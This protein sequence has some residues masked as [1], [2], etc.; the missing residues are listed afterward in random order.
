[1]RIV[2]GRWRGRTIDAPKGAGTR[3]TADRVRESLM[4]AL[5]SARGGFN[6]AVVLDPFAGSGALGLEALSRGAACA[7]F[8]ESDRAA[9]G[10]LRR[11]VDRLGCGGAATIRAADVFSAPPPRPQTPFDLVLLDPPYKTDPI[12]VFALLDRIADAG[13]LAPGALVSYEH[14]L[15]DDVAAAAGAARAEWRRRAGKKYGKLAVDL[16]E[17]RAEGSVGG[18]RGEG[19]GEGGG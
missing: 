16:F 11:N 13:A 10:V 6:G 2:A 4:S 3:P 9:V 5:A 14:A 18:R 7:W 1:M 15:A 19:A 8:F 12:A 17:L